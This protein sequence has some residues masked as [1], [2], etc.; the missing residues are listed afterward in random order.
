MEYTHAVPVPMAIRVCMLAWRWR[1]AS[2]ALAK[3][4]LPEYARTASE[5]TPM[6][7]HSHHSWALPRVNTSRRP[8]MSHG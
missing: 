3:N 1:R 8:G 5:A 6:A 7:T 2:Q 4:W